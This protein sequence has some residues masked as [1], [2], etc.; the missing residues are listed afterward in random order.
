MS[1]QVGQEAPDFALKDQD[2]QIRTLSEFR[3]RKNVMLVFYPLAFSRICTAELCQLR[4]DLPSFN[5]DDTI[6]LGVSVDSP[7]VLKAFAES[8][9]Y[10]FPLLSDFWPHGATAKTYG[11]FNEERGI[12]IRGTF[13]IDK[14]GIVRYEVVNP[15]TEPR[16]PDA[17]RKALAALS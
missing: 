17:Y 1:I 8:Q 15:A 9:G 5:N 11:V 10:Q 2:G 14:Q 16:D 13:I 4:D 3:G 12:A 6:T 7:Y